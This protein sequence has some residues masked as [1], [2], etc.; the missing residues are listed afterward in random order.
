MTQINCPD[1]ITEGMK[2]TGRSATRSLDKAK[3]DSRDLFAFIAALKEL[4]ETDSD[5]RKSVIYADFQLYHLSLTFMLELHERELDS[6]KQVEGLTMSIIDG[7]VVDS[8]HFT[9]LV[10]LTGTLAQYQYIIPKMLNDNS[11]TDDQEVLR[12]QIFNQIYGI[13][14]KLNLKDL[15]HQYTEHPERDGT[16]TLEHK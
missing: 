1:F 4:K 7:S 15:L 5:P 3:I 10:F 13:L 16:F 8:R 6:L 2:T 9:H 14:K 11:T 12:R